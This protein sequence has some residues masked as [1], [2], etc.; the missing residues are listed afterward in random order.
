MTSMSERGFHI[1]TRKRSWLVGTLLGAAGLF[2]G[3][4]PATA[5]EASVELQN[6]V[7]LNEDG[8][9]EALVSY[10]CSPDAAG[11]SVSVWL[12][13]QQTKKNATTFGGDGA[14]GW[15]SPGFGTF[16]T[17]TCS[18]SIET[19]A[20]T[21]PASSGPGFGLG[22]AFVDVDFGFCSRTACTYLSTGDFVRVGK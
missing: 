11:W 13:V 20:V 9:L 3:A 15:Y 8:S 16:G 12:N 18:G 6:P 10:S 19:V 17:M 22:K 21:I 4:V 1:M 5:A 14:G 7:T 2:F